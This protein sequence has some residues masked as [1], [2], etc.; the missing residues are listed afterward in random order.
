MRDPRMGLKCWTIVPLAIATLLGSTAATR[1]QSRLTFR[2]PSKTMPQSEL[3]VRGSGSQ[4]EAPVIHPLESARSGDSPD[5]PQAAPVPR[6]LWLGYRA[7]RPALQVSQNRADS[8]LPDSKLA[9]HVETAPVEESFVYEFGAP[10]PWPQRVFLPTWGL[11]YCPNYVL[12][13]WHSYCH[14]RWRRMNR[15]LAGKCCSGHGQGNGCCRTALLGRQ[16]AAVPATPGE[17]CWSHSPSSINSHG[18]VPQAESPARTSGSE[19]VEVRRGSSPES[20]PGKFYLG[21][22]RNPLPP[23]H[24]R[25]PKK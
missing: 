16:F 22:P 23:Q 5:H 25:S 1:A 4:N 19:R 11:P 12:D 18:L 7:L 9:L 10:G 21:V 2:I 13:P 14:E 24:L 17:G 8:I 15:L 3:S 6:V 20:T